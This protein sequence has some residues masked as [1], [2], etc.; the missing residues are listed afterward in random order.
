VALEL[1]Q[2][3]SKGIIRAD[4]VA[5]GARVAVDKQDFGS[6]KLWDR[7]GRRRREKIG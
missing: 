4:K 2:R 5:R 6:I 3:E 1:T 7:K